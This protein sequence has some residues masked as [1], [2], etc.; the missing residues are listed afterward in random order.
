[1]AEQVVPVIVEYDPITGVPSEYNEFLPHDTIEYK[2]WKAASEGPEGLEKLTL[3]DKATG[4]EIEKQLPGGKV[5][6][7][8][9]AQILLQVAVRNKNKNTTS[10]SGLELFGVKL[11]EASKAFGKKFACGASVTKTP[12]GTEQIEMQGDF[13]HQLAEL[14]LKLYG[15][16]NK[17]TKDDVFYINEKKTVN[18][19]AEEKE[20]DE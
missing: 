1:M 19:F 10:V 5:K 13:L 6:K 14:I 15:N 18:Y 2:K 11:S 12:A 17:I 4:E 9:K 20:E 7:K 16:S 8:Q 3:K